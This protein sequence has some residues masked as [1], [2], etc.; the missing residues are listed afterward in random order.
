MFGHEKVGGRHTNTILRPETF[1]GVHTTIIERLR[2]YKTPFVSSHGT[3]T[4]V[5]EVS[6]CKF[7]SSSD[8]PVRGSFGMNGLDI[9]TLLP[10]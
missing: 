7:N 6:F 10:S 1:N 8:A 5:Q 3:K 9:A 4:M 2:T